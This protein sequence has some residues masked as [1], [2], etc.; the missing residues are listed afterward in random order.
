MGTRMGTQ[1]S[2]SEDLEQ[3]VLLSTEPSLQFLCFGFRNRVSSCLRTHSVTNLEYRAILLLLL[4]LPQLLEWWGD[5]CELHVPG[6]KCVF[7]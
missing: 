5:R 2:G 3:C 1:S 7:F 6:I 4:L